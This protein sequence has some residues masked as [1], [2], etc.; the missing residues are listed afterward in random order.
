MEP[1]KYIVCATKNIPDTPP[2]LVDIIKPSVTPGH[3]VIVLIQNG[4]NIEKPFLEAF[5]QN[6]V[7]SG[8]SRC[9]SH[10]IRPAEIVQD[11]YDKL[12]VAPFRNSSLNPADE[13]REAKDFCDAYAAGGKCEATFDADVSFGRWRKLVYNACLNPISAA[14][15]MDT[16]RLRLA[17]DAVETLV[18]PAMEEI[19]AAA[20]A[21]GINLPEDVAQSMIDADPIRVYC[22]PSMQMD[23]KEVS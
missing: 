14:L 15:D 19:R 10:Q 18:R 2:S 9:G 22:I 13:D 4:L 5:P 3:T 11:D 16:G 20:T 17:D 7:L 1:F 21:C 12:L 6:V 8:V 23:I